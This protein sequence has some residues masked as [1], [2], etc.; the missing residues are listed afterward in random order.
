VQNSKTPVIKTETVKQ[1]P[2]TVTEE[3]EKLLAEKENPELN[4]TG[5]IKVR[6]NHYNKSFPVHNGVLK[7]AC[8]DSEY[9]IS[10]VFRGNCR[11]DLQQELSGE[12]RNIQVSETNCRRDELG[13]YFLGL[14][15]NNID[16]LEPVTYRLTL[17]EDPVAGVGAEGLRLRGGPLAL[18][19]ASEGLQ[20]GNKAVSDIT[21]S[22][23]NMKTSDLNSQEAN[24]LRERR[25]LE[26]ILYS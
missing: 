11:R 18:S 10:F 17:E 26:D 13:V 25:D 2:L 14:V 19:K 8:V 24:D 20:S 16:S 12:G 7:W 5:F 22:L 3:A 4:G 1:K 6:F 21:T 9:C 23:L 15:A